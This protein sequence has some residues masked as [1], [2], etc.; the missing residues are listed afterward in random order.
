MKEYRSVCKLLGS[1]EKY[2]EGFEPG[3]LIQENTY[4]HSG[5]EYPF[6]LH[7]RKLVLAEQHGFKELVDFLQNIDSEINHGWFEKGLRSS[8]VDHGFREKNYN[9]IEKEGFLDCKIADLA[10]KANTNRN[11]R[12]DSVQDLMLKA[13]KATIG[14]E[15]PVWYYDKKL[16]DTVT[17]HI[18]VLQVRNNKI[19]ILDY[20]PKAGSVEPLGQLRSY[21]KGLS[22]RTGISEDRFRAAWFNSDVYKEISFQN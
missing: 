7:R 21:V 14:T 4:F 18:D 19:Y 13:D 20:K 17:G 15:V 6:R 1:R 9:I 12:H 22:Y 5:V 3:E 16:E 11:K 10:L 2:I 8:Q